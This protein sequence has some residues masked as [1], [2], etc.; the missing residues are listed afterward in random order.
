ML[1][2]NYLDKVERQAL[3]IYGQLEVEIIKEIVDRINAVGY[4]NAV[5]RNDVLIAQELGLL[6]TNVVQAVSKETNK[7]YDEIY[8][9]FKEAG[10]TTIK[11]DDKI[12]KMAGLNPININQDKSMLDLLVSSTYKTNGNL[13]NLTMTTATTSQEKFYNI[14]NKAYMEVSTGVKSYSQSIMDAIDD[15]AESG[16]SVLYPSG[17]KT[18]LENAVRMNVMTGVNQTCGKMQELR[19]EELGWDL[20]E[21]TA[22]NDSRPSHAEWQG[23]IVSLSGKKG[24]LS[25]DDIGYGTVDGFKGINCRHDWNPYFEGSPRTWSDEQLEEMKNAKVTYNGKEMSV[26]EAEQLQRKMERQIRVDKKKIAGRQRLLTG[27][28]TDTS[29]KELKASLNY[30]KARLELHKDELNNL[31]TQTNISLEQYRTKIDKKGSYY[32]KNVVNYAEKLYN[33][34]SK[35]EN[36]T[37]YVKDEVIRRHIRNNQNLQLNTGAQDKHIVGTNNYNTEIKNGNHPSTLD[38]NYDEIE[39]LVKE[40]AG[41]GKIIRNNGR[42]QKEVIIVNRDIGTFVDAKTGK[43]IEK[44]N[45]ATI[46]Y[47]QNGKYHVVPAK[48]R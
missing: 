24:Y 43:I 29:E 7:S 14:I 26:Y 3:N 37:D 15:L 42:L 2:P 18:S 32:T 36:L 46:H 39:D 27:I 16:A 19:A 20:M 4:A 38:L 22:H 17:Y 6:Y 48:R 28:T 45:S 12:Y 25:K 40:Y 33:N 5:V 41:T 9:I 35:E 21:I 31:S 44:T 10:V 47:K 11:N 34:A 30:Q 13:T 23:K 1:P 8:K